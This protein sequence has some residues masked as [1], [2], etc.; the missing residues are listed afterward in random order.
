MGST[1]SHGQRFR[2]KRVDPTGLGGVIN[3]YANHNT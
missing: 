3:G 1:V 2:G